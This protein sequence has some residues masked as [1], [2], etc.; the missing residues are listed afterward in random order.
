MAL[1]LEWI[2]DQGGKPRAE[3]WATSASD[4]FD[5]LARKLRLDTSDYK[6]WAQTNDDKPDLCTVYSIPNTIHIDFGVPETSDYIPFFSV[7]S[8]W[9]SMAMKQKIAWENKGFFV[10]VAEGVIDSEIT[11]H[12][13]DENIYGYLF[14]GHGD[15][16]NINTYSHLG[17]DMTGT[18][19]DRY[20]PHGIAFLT[21]K[22]CDSASKMDGI[23]GKTYRFNV[24]ESNVARRGWFVGYSGGVTTSTESFFWTIAPGQNDGG[25]S[26]TD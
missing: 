9:R 21:L 26:G 14:I 15:S 16:G 17:E 4:T 12:L 2:I 19:P 11:D 24:W 7:I 6:K 13:K 10:P 1:G 20:T 25:Y 18:S 8:V 22:T 3:A 5:D 23:I